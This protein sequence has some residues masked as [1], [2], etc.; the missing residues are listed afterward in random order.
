MI[1][2]RAESLRCWHSPTRAF[3]YS[4]TCPTPPF[5]PSICRIP[6]LFLSLSL[7][8]PLPALPLTRTEVLRAIVQTMERSSLLLRGGGTRRS[9][10]YAT[11]I[12]GIGLQALMR[13]L[14]P[15]H[16][17]HTVH[18]L[19]ENGC[20]AVQS[21]GVRAAVKAVWGW[22]WWG[23]TVNLVG[24]V[25]WQHLQGFHVQAHSQVTHSCCLDAR[26]LFRLRPYT[27]MHARACSHT[28]AHMHLLTRATH[29]NLDITL[30]RYDSCHH[31]EVA[32]LIWS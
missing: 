24:S 8:L 22:W 3:I 4:L 17:Q 20:A 7:P 19:S 21:L 27:R 9:E 23:G 25:L 14:C 32:Q 11:E 13:L 26:S 5:C 12:F 15:I 10:E 6:P 16:A 30:Y 18:H 2:D 31:G 29:E 28:Y 1:L